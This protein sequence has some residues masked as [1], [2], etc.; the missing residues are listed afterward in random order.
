MPLQSRLLSQIDV[1][2][3]KLIKVFKRRGGQ[4]GRRLQNILEPTAQ[5]ADEAIIQRSNKE[6][7]MGIYIIKSRD[8]NGS[9]EDIGIVLE[10]QRVWQDLDNY[11]LAAAV[12]FGLMYTL[13]LTYPLEKY[14]LEG[15]WL[16]FSIRLLSLPG[17]CPWAP[18]QGH[19]SSQSD[20][21][22]TLPFI[23][24]QF[25]INSFPGLTLSQTSSLSSTFGFRIPNPH[26]GNQS[27][28]HL[29]ALSSLRI[30]VTLLS[31]LPSS[32]FK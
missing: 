6:T 32:S 24:C 26:F 14:T 4:R 9:P 27:V 29:P 31:S 13:N 8:T 22:L 20:L 10:G 18:G 19:Q 7:T 3:D 12:L 21:G 11:T 1:L 28:P 17:I 5:A 25:I 30:C 16:E 23:H 2:S 15:V